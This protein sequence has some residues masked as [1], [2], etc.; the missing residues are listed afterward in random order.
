VVKPLKI[1]DVL[2]VV[3]RAVRWRAQRT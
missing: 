2:D 1:D 3:G